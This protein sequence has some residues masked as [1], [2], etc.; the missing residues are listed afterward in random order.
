ME[1][2]FIDLCNK[3][4][5]D[6]AKELLK[7]YPDINISIYN[8]GAFRWACENKHLKV[9]KWLQ[10]LKPYLY[11][12]KYDIYGNYSGYKIRT[13]EE[14]IWEQRKYALHL[15][16]QEETNIL[17]HLPIDIAKTVTLFV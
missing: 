8:D 13:K 10:S 4:Y 12:I 11:V 5:L 6:E 9:A 2:L 3:G 15:A 7:K 1:D 16:L 17:Y 14:V